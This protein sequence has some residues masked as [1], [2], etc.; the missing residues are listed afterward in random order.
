MDQSQLRDADSSGC[1]NTDRSKPR[2]ARREYER[3][4]R[5]RGPLALSRQ[6][7]AKGVFQLRLTANIK[8]TIE[9]LS[10]QREWTHTG[11]G[12]ETKESA[13][14]LEGWS[15]V[16]SGLEPIIWMRMPRGVT[17]TAT[18]I[19]IAKEDGITPSV[20]PTT[21]KRNVW[22]NPQWQQR[23]R[24]YRASAAGSL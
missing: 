16:A 2:R 19:N 15:R 3:M 20:W 8:R 24:L 21:L 17:A 12:W 14:R 1:E 18:I 13:V 9:R 6:S 7:V 10:R 23:W 22:L 11:Q 5:D 4:R